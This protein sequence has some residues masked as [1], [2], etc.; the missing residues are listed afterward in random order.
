MALLSA[1]RLPCGLQHFRSVR[2]KPATQQ[3][4]ACRNAAGI[5]VV[6]DITDRNSFER[7]LRW[8]DEL[9]NTM[10]SDAIL[11]LVG[12]PRHTLVS[13]AQ[14][15]TVRHMWL[16]FSCAMASGFASRCIMPGAG[17][18]HCGNKTSVVRL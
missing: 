3:L 4:S 2:F 12:T 7:A 16:C 10:P 17:I 18:A 5:L 6:Y 8:L 1:A 9:P 15:H 14:S 13:A 11:I